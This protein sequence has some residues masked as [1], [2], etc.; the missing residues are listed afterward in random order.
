MNKPLIVVFVGV[1]GSGKTTF[2][3]Q[4]AQRLDGVVLSSDAI[5]LS[6]YGSREEADA[7]RITPEERKYSNQLV[8][9]ALNYATRQIAKAGHSVVFDAIA[10][11]RVERQEKYDFAKELGVNAVV[12]RIEVPYE[13][14]LRRM[15]EREALEDQRQ[16]HEE[17]AIGVLEH[18]TNEIQEPDEDENVIHI[19]G[20]APFEEQYEHFIQSYQRL[21]N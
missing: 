7:R 11:R 21:F 5:R 2:A 4:L 3:R 12:V 6:M 18:F 13:V 17:K 14:S 8:F 20:E 9:G 16:F 10:S 1:P 19:D 15:Q